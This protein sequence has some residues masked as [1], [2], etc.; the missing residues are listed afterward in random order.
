MIGLS[1]GAVFFDVVG[2]AHV[3]GSPIILL[4]VGTGGGAVAVVV[5]VEEE[6]PSPTSEGSVGGRDIMDVSSAVMGRSGINARVSLMVR[7]LLVGGVEMSE[8]SSGAETAGDVVGVGGSEEVGGVMGTETAEEVG[9]G[10]AGSGGEMGT[11]RGRGSGAGGA[12]G[13]GAVVFDAKGLLTLSFGVGLVFGLDTSGRS[14]AFVFF[15]V[16]DSLDEDFRFEP[17]TLLSL[18][19]LSSS[20][21]LSLSIVVSC[22]SCLTELK[23]PFE[24]FALRQDE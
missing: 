22:I 13:V 5:A 2:G 12:G 19:S 17:A 10:E 16:G 20:S 3:V 23:L 24:F 1:A 8:D 4:P 11:G 9:V 21:S 7:G 14:F 18:S 6:V 15:G